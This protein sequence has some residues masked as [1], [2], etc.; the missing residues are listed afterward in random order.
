MAAVEMIAAL[1]DNAMFHKGPFVEHR[2]P[3]GFGKT[4]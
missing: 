3:T 1:T 2:N 4:Q